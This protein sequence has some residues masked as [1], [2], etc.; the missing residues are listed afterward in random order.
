MTTSGITIDRAVVRYEMDAASR[1]QQPRF[2]RILAEDVGTGLETALDEVMWRFGRDAIVCVKR[3]EIALCLDLS[4]PDRVVADVW[5]DAVA[6]AVM[7][8]FDR[9]GDNVIVYRTLAQPLSELA[10]AA[11]GGSDFRAWTWNQLGLWTPTDGSGTAGYTHALGRAARTLPRVAPRVLVEA[12]RRDRTMLRRLTD[13]AP[14]I[15]TAVLCNAGLPESAATRLIGDTAANDLA[16]EPAGQG[17]AAWSRA[18]GG[19]I[20]EA[21]QSY[22]L[23]TP[24]AQA[25]AIIALA[26]SEP[27]R[28]QRDRALAVNDWLSGIGHQSVARVDDP[29]ETRPA[30]VT[31]CDSDTSGAP[32]EDQ[33]LTPE[34]IDTVEPAVPDPVRPTDPDKAVQPTDPVTEWGGV[35][36]VLNL[37]DDAVLGTLASAPLRPA[38]ITTAAL[39]TGAPEDDPGIQA[40]AGCLGTVGPSQLDSAVQGVDRRDEVA[41][42]GPRNAAALLRKQLAD[43]GFTDAAGVMQRRA[44]LRAAPGWLE[45]EFSIDDVDLDV[46]RA[47]LDIDPDWLPWLGTVVTFRYG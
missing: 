39:L 14:A 17:I 33:R 26:G 32:P 44:V 45:A 25:W 15:A 2:D 4:A 22:Q 9:G 18:Q 13:D 6:A 24:A 47:G 38:L 16:S 35:L 28:L 10:E 46:R 7:D 34:S 8:L 30:D 21:L 43:L 12:V 31:W 27:A 11:L 5:S 19:V 1:G 41:M 36:F 40:F 20:R 29:V 3:L 23:P 37:V 42:A